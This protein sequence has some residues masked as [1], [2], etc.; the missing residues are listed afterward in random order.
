MGLY[1]TKRRPIGTE[2]NREGYLKVKI[3]NGYDEKNYK[4]KHVLVW[5]EA[6]GPIPEGHVVIFADRNKENFDLDNLILVS[7]K[8]LCWMNH[9]K[10]IQSEKDLT[11]AA[12]VVAKIKILIADRERELGGRKDK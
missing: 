10:L 11:K 1:K 6:N 12:A 3:K 4:S 8:E 9:N 2:I 7:K 5:E